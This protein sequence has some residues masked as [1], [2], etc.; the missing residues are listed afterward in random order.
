MIPL[1]ILM[2]ITVVVRVSHGWIEV[3]LLDLPVLRRRHDERVRLLRREPAGGAGHELAAREVPAV[4][5][6]AR[7]RDG[8]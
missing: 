2:P 7:H 8:P 3:L 5:H 1:A 6:G 4:P